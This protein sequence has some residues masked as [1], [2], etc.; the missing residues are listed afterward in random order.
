MMRKLGHG[1]RIAL[2]WLVASTVGDVLVAT[3]LT[4]H[5]PPGTGSTEASGQRFDNEVLT[6]VCIPIIALILVFFSYVLIVF[7]RRTGAPLTDGP[8]IRGNARVQTIWIASTTLIVLFL[9]AFG[10]YELLGGAGGGQGS[11]PVFV[12]DASAASLAQGAKPLQV[13]VIAQQWQ[14]T[15]RYPDDGGFESAQFV[16][17]VNR[18]VELH[19][20]SLDVIH[21]FW[22]PAL[23]VK[24]DANPGAD[25]IAYVTPTKV[26]SLHIECAELCGLFHGY[27]FDTGR[28]VSAAAFATF[29][30]KQRAFVAPVTRYLPKYAT[31]YLPEPAFRAG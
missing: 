10:T 5:L 20:T 29:V 7:R 13:Q 17:P 11:G 9:A 15:Y 27:M 28:V 6:L 4:P 3:V 31:T 21:S 25:N 30:A 2:I 22:V 16:L 8:P 12:P 14:F 26:Q 1:A 18:Q 23:G 24:A 19:V